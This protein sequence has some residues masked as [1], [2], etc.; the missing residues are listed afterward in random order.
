MYNWVLFS[1]DFQCKY[2]TRDKKGGELLFF[3]FLK[4]FDVFHLVGS[5]ASKKN[6]HE[7]F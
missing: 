1:V 5:N 2:G 7:E 6:I 3:T 4:F